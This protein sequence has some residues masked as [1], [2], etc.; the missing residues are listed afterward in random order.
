MSTSFRTHWM[1]IICIT[2]TIF[3][4]L[5]AIGHDNDPKARDRQPPYTGPG[6]RSALN[7]LAGVDP[8]AR[9]ASG[10]LQRQRLLG[11]H[12]SQRA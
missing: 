12:F 5:I 4:G 7:Q 9:D 1:L 8:L 6:Y 2:C 10:H 11:L 3:G